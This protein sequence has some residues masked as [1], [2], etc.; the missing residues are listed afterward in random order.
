M[1][2][3]VPFL[4]VAAVI[5]STLAQRLRM[6][7]QTVW[8][9]AGSGE[10]PGWTL[11]MYWSFGELLADASRGTVLRP[12]D[13]IGSQTVETGCIYLI[14]RGFPHLPAA[15]RRLVAVNGADAYSFGHWIRIFAGAAAGCSGSCG[16]PRDRRA[17]MP[18]TAVSWSLSATA[19]WRP[20]PLTKRW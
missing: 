15:G 7:F 17:A 11:F 5:R 3:P 14:F 10:V 2:Q 6:S 13:I 12:G 8:V 18:R 4:S 9:G 16:L 20:P 19:C 1:D